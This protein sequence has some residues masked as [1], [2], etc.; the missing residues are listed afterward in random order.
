[1]TKGRVVA[2]SGAGGSLGPS[3][4]RAFAA[5]GA[6]LALA[7]REAEKLTA[8][9]DAAHV[10]ADRR[11]VTAV[12]L[13]DPAAAASWA[14][15]VV[16]AF[17]RVDTVLHLVGGY[18][19][20]TTI[21]EIADADWKAL[22]DMLV[23]TTLNVVRAFAGPL[24]ASGRG[25]LVAVTSPKAREPSAKGALYAMAKSASDALVRAY[26]DE[27]KGTGTT[28]NLIEVDSIDSPETR[29]AAGAGAATASPAGPKKPYG[30]TTPAEEVAAAMVY[31]CSDEAATINGARL[32]LTG[33][34]LGN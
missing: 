11:L 6:V 34:G 25:R 19:P 9:L 15:A 1:M 27:V 29:G 16:G 10:P 14:G 32:P 7:G 31:L 13:Q 4:V 5:G 3:V 22:H 33:R 18:R 26:A 24:K 23:L 17:G 30:K 2:I 21:A 20:G 28:A 8:L 12:D